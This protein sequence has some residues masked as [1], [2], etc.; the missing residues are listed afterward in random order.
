MLI[1]SLLAQA[2]AAAAPQP[3]ASLPQGV[4]SYP[5]L[6]FEGQQVANASEM[7]ARVPGFTL[8]TG[9]EVRGFEGAAGNVLIDGQRPTSKSDTLDQILVRIPASQV[10]RIDVI[11]GGAPGVDMQGKS[12]IANVV[13][14]KGG[15]WRGLFQAVE[16][17]LWDGR[18]MTGMRLELSGGDGE[19]TWEATARYGYGNDDGGEFGPL[20]RLAPDGTVLRRADVKSE[21]DGLQQTLTAA[22]SQPL[23]GGR[24]SLNGRAFWDSWKSEETDRFT[25]PS[26][27]G[28]QSDVNPYDEFQT[29]VGVRYSRDLGASTR[30]ELVGLR[31]DTDYHTFDLFAFGGDSSEFRNR[32]DLSEA[33]GRAVL[34]HQ[35]SDTLS[36]EVGGEGA[37][38]ELDSRSSAFE[39]GVPVPIPAAAVQVRETRGEGFAKAAWRASPAWTFDGSLRFEASKISSEGDVVLEKTLSFLKPRLAASWN[40][41]RG[42]Q[43]RMSIERVVGQLDFDDFVAGSDFTGGVGVTAGNPDLDPQQAWAAEAAVEQRFWKGAAVTLTFRHSELKD[44]VDRGPVRLTTVDPDTGESR[45]VVFDQPTNIGDGTKDELSATLNLPFDHFGWNGALLRGE[46]HR[47]W[48]SVTDPTTL[49]HRTISRLRPL[50]W[51]AHFSQDLPSKGL[52]LGFD[53]FGGWSQDTYRFNYVQEVRLHNAYLTTWVEKRL[54]PDTIVRFEIGNW[55]RRGIRFANHIYDGPRDSGALLYTDNRE[56]KPGHNVYIRVRRTFGG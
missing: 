55:T 46:V 54:D 4:I 48:S 40:A 14:K 44:V 25:Q 27:L 43:L 6:F 23:L 9:E 45:V 51:E 34:K 39:N 1:S 33:I 2:A 16:N 3:A 7:L 53:L 41:R 49:T 12:V 36:V 28:V 22:W 56:L 15:G 21:S 20:V 50:E 47:R 19:R 5:A 38:N 17:H 37:V 11:R 8:D 32:R 35:L 10:E 24:I 52:S 31:T 30:L 18:N 26:G 13:K 42:T 29:E